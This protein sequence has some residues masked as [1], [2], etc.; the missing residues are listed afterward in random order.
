VKAGKTLFLLA[1]FGVALGVAAVLSIQIINRNALAAFRGSL[2]AVSG[3]ADLSILGTSA[4]FPEQLYLSVLADRG[5]EAAWPACRATVAVHGRDQVFLDLVGVDL[6]QATRLPIDSGLADVGSALR[7]AGWVALT[8]SFA[9][10][11]G[12]EPGDTIPTSL[13][14]RRVTLSVGAL[15]DFQTIAPLASSKLAV[16]DIAQAQALFGVRGAINQIDVL[17]RNGEEVESARARLSAALGPGVEVLT[18][19]QREQRASNLLGAFR[20]NLTALSLISLFVGLFLVYSSTQASLVRRRAEFGLLRSLGATRGQVLAVIL[21]ETALLGAA[22]VAVGLPMGYWVAAANV[23]AVSATIS[24]LY[25]LNEIETLQLPPSLYLLAASIGIGGALIAALQP[26]VDMS[27]R[28]P[29]S[30]L[31]PFTLHERLKTAAGP[32]FVAGM[33]ILTLTAIWFVLIGR[34]WRPAGFVLAVS[35]LIGLSLLTPLVIDRLTHPMRVRRLGLVYSLKTLG[36]RLQ[37]AAVAVAA[38]AIAVSM[39]VGITMMVGSFRRTVDVW[40]GTTVRADVY[41]TSESWSRS[42]SSAQLD[43]QLVSE[44]SALPGVMAVDRLRAVSPVVAGRRIFLAGVDLSLALTGRF[45]LLRGNDS[46]ASVAVR[47]EG[48]AL[49]SEPLS[50]RLQIGVGDT[51]TVPRPDGNVRL[52]IAAVYYDYGYESGAAVIDLAT[53]ERH[54]GPG[55]ISNLALYLDDQYD[56]EAAVDE[57][58]AL[59]PDAPLRVRSNRRLRQEVLRIFDQ[60]FA[61]TR[62][63]QVMSL[64]VATTGIALTLIVLARE[65][66]SELAVYR[67]LGATRR[68]IFGI[69]VGKGVAMAV[70]ALVLGAAGGAILACVLIYVVNRS[71]FGW[72]IQFHW[73]LAE[74]AQQ[75]ATIIIAAVAASLFPA[76]RASRTPAT[77]L[78]RDDL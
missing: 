52:P 77:E 59:Y 64:I 4:T 14:S 51:L 45:S 40:I 60:T 69:F 25:M 56:A 8:P 17:L 68:Q 53:M 54:F 23:E 1:A 11:L 26:A 62:I 76:L 22:G 7:V 34:A 46:T 2:E 15:V 36:A 5:V 61:I 65:R 67:A 37:T 57:I 13:G 19:V 73:P 74:L 71:Y 42:V 35:L 21:F 9:A 43:D 44:L 18:P 48:A 63:L 30:L 24:N 6:F 78:S 12:V 72:T 50:R 29:S 55:R 75:A 38:L 27:R 32:L 49:I 70:I 20:L 39:L 58:R 3:Q 28:D 31:T 33:A 16:M 47:S 10:D 41:I 66:L